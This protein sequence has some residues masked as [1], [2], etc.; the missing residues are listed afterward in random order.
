MTKQAKA[1]AE[2]LRGR[3]Q[4]IVTFDIET[5]P[6]LAYVWSTWKQNIS[7]NQIVSDWRI[8]SISWK[9]LGEQ[10]VNYV[11]TFAGGQVLDDSSLLRKAWEILDEADI[12]VGQNSKDFDIRKLNARFIE[13]GYAPPRPYKQVD[14]KVEAAKVARFTSNKL[15]WLAP[16]VAGVEKDKH[17][18]FPGF[19][20]WT[21]CLSGNPKAWAE[22]RKYNVKDVRATEELYVKLRPWIVGHP[23][24]STE[25]DDGHAHCPKCG[26][27]DLE[28]RGKVTTQAGMYTQY[29]CRHCGGWSRSRYTENRIDQRRLLLSN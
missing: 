7:N 18:N 29:R 4:R 8:L 2:A 23:N 19:E 1:R 3:E 15:E 20:L 6:I 25:L 17:K 11:D 28:K 13:S 21:E 5:S 27:D 14:T 24:V 16:I 26:S 22:M 12:V 9:W 10:K